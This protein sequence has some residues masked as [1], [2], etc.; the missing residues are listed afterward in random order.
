LQVGQEVVVG[1]L[2][3]CLLAVEDVIGA[4]GREDRG[5]HRLAG[6]AAGA[7]AVSLDEAGE[8]ADGAGLNDFEQLG[9]GL[10]EVFAQR[11]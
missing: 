6:I 7:G 4:G 2:Q 10:G 8:R 9:S 5:D 11:F 1:V 3:R